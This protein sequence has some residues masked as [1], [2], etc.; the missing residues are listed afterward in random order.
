[1]RRVAKT[2][3]WNFTPFTPFSSFLR[4]RLFSRWFAVVR[5]HRRGRNCSLFSNAYQLPKLDVVGSNPISRSIF[6][7]TYMVIADRNFRENGVNRSKSPQPIAPIG[8]NANHPRW[9]SA[10]FKRLYLRQD[11]LP[12]GHVSEGTLFCPFGS[13]LLILQCRQNFAM[14]ALA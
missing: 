14:K 11:K 6:S 12:G 5:M 4:Q 2:E 8:M 7:I 9:P 1:M 13:R 10:S 3:S